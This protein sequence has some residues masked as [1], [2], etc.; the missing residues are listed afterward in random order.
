MLTL[1]ILSALFISNILISAWVLKVV[2]RKFAA[3]RTSYSVALGCILVLVAVNL[4]MALA[5]QFVPDLLNP[6]DESLANIVTF[7]AFLFGIKISCVAFRLI[8]G[9][10]SGASLL[11]WLST[12][13]PSAFFL[14][15]VYVIIIPFM[16][17]G[18]IASTN[19]MA[20]TIVAYHSTGKCPHC[21]NNSLVLPL[22]P[23]NPQTPPGVGKPAQDGICASC[24]KIGHCEAPSDNVAQPDRF[25][26]SKLQRAER[27]DLVVFRPKEYPEFRYV[28]RLIGLPGEEVFIEDGSVWINGVKQEVPASI[29]G[30]EY[31]TKLPVGPKIR[32]GTREEPI[33]VGPGE[34]C[35]LGD[36][37][38]QVLDSR[39]TGPVPTANVEGVVTLR[40]WPP[41]RMRIWK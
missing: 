10:K 34:C 3:Q 16:L 17:E 36:F 35:L 22:I 30:I 13:I 2:A 28:Q 23:F 21:G 31:A 25:M 7:V 18:F 27:W 24:F 33:R 6:G 11:I 20:P 14:V 39:F 26:E 37:S 4:L 9:V 15:V 5:A 32:F 8:L 29:A 38:L 41:G 12:L 40:Y 19:S 1:L